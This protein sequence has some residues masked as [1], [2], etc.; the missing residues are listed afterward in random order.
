MKRLIVSVNVEKTLFINWL[1][2]ISLNQLSL[3][4]FAFWS[5]GEVF[6]E[7]TS[8]ES[9]AP[10]VGLA[11]ISF[12]I[13]SL[14]WVILLLETTILTPPILD[15]YKNSIYLS[16]AS[17]ILKFKHFSLSRRPYLH[18]LPI[19]YQQIQLRHV[20]HSLRRFINFLKY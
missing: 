13:A 9:S 16:K 10:S 2:K 12:L 14:Q 18:L 8:S 1:D 19:C 17:S 20:S 7:Y 11:S 5:I 6:F 4:K 15:V 3:S